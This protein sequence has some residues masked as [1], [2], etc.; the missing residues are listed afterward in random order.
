MQ[1]RKYKF[2]EFQAGPWH[3]QT[4]Q[5]LQSLLDAAAFPLMGTGTWHLFIYFFR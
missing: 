2:W 3:L 5:K 4:S 1:S